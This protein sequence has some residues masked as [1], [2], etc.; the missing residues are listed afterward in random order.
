MKPI[1]EHNAELALHSLEWFP[2]DPGKIAVCFIWTP[3]R[4]CWL[5]VRNVVPR[6][7]FL[8]YDGKIDLIGKPGGTTAVVERRDMTE[9][10]F[11]SIPLEETPNS[12]KQT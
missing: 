8:N 11:N 9:A 7:G 5:A 2:P 1:A 6:C 4:D 10:E 3:E 12:C